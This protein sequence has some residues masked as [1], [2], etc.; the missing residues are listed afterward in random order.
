MKSMIFLDSRYAQSTV[1]KALDARTGS[2]QLTIMRQFPTEIAGFFWYE[3]TAA[4][5]LDLLASQYLGDTN[6]WWKI[7]DVNPEVINPLNIAPGTQLR[8]PNA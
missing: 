3:W 8:I 7:M 6:M 1:F 4:D 5:R 2:Y